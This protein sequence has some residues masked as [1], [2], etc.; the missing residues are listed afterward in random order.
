[1]SKQGKPE[2]PKHE[3]DLDQLVKIQ[4]ETINGKPFYGTVLDDELIYIWVHVFQRKLDKLFGVTSTKS[5]TRNVRG[6]FK[7]KVPTKLHEI[8]KGP[9]FSYEKFMDDGNSEVITGKVLGY[10]ASKPAQI[11]ELVKVSIKTNFGV[12]PT[13]IQNWL[14]LFGILT[15]QQGDFV[16][17]STNGTRSDVYEAEIVLKKHIPEYLPMYGQKVQVNYPGIPRVCNRCFIDGHLRRDC[18]NQKKDWVVYIIELVEQGG[19]HIDLVGS[20]KNAIQRWK[21]AN[22]STE[23]AK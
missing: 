13:G 6:T 14:R 2:P 3:T 20:W 4:L 9:E 22:A 12:E 17:N 21:K 1:M 23:G 5:L 8:V 15:A 18:N 11:G 19:V 10:G 7:L 16:I